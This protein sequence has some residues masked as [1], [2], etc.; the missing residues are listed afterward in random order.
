[1]NYGTSISLTILFI[2]SIDVKFSASASYVIP[3]LCCNTSCTTALAL[4][5]GSYLTERGISIFSRNLLWQIC[6]LL[7][8]LIVLVYPFISGGFDHIAY[9]KFPPGVAVILGLLIALICVILFMGSLMFR[10]R[11]FALRLVSGLAGFSTALSALLLLCAQFPWTAMDGSMTLEH[12]AS[13]DMARS[14]SQ[15]EA[16]SLI[17]T[18]DDGTPVTRQEVGRVFTNVRLF[19]G[20]CWSIMFFLISMGAGFLLMAIRVASL[21]VPYMEQMAR[22]PDSAW[23]E[24]AARAWRY[25]LQFR[26]ILSLAWFLM[27]CCLFWTFCNL[28]STTAQLALEPI[29][30]GKSQTLSGIDTSVLFA[31]LALGA[32]PGNAV[33]ALGVQSI[34]CLYILTCWSLFAISCGGWVIAQLSDIHR[35]RVGAS[36]NH[37]T[38]AALS[39][40]AELLWRR[41]FSS[42]PPIVIMLDGV[43]PMARAQRIGILHRRNVIEVTG[44]CTDLL[45]DDELD[46]LLAHE[47]AHHVGKHCLI[48]NALRLAGRITLVGDG[49]V[50]TLEDSFGYE[51][52]ADREAVSS[53]AVSADALK[54]CVLK[55]QTYAAA[56]QLR[57]F[58]PA[59]GGGG[60]VSGGGVGII[61]AGLVG[62]EPDNPT[63]P[64]KGLK[65]TDRFKVCLRIYWQQ[66]VG[67]GYAAYWHP[68]LDYRI[69][70]LD[71]QIRIG[72]DRYGQAVK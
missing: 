65:I 11:G 27:A 35:F 32:R 51:L 39:K 63:G 20:A 31:R 3:I 25:L 22:R 71:E 36:R 54:R 23:S 47:L 44:C 57:Q 1:M 8:I 58:R 56:A 37:K 48:D 15:G 50:R 62:G 14:Y 30:A 38:G 7:F 16:I 59:S 34:W 26:I 40:R 67:S 49:F 21:G 18:H 45:D 68:A 28:V 69:S 10:H 9:H 72:S 33:I 55:L 60:G 12:A 70:L 42:P 41:R 43:V 53:F 64:V 6:Y 13:L 19:A 2:M 5:R 52:Q 66:Y 29:N 17:P 61:D 4:Q 46:A 24:R